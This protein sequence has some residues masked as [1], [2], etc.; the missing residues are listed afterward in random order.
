[1]LKGSEDF[2]DARFAG[3]GR[4]KDGFDVFGFRGRKLRACDC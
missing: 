2:C 3:M 4:H 1:M